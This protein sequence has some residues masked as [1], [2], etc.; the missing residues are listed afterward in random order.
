MKKNSKQLSVATRAIH[1]SKLYAFKGPVTTPIYQTSTYRFETSEDAIRY[2]KGDPSVYVYSRYHN[3]TVHDVEEKIA[4]ME[5]SEAAALFSS[6]MAA[7]TT[8]ILAV[9]K[10]G[11]NIISTSAL[12]GGTYRWMRDE[13][14][15]RNITVHFVDA[16]YLEDI[17]R[18]ADE[19]T[20]IV[21]IE[22]PTNPTLS[23]VD[24]S[25]AVRCTKKAEKRLGRRILTMIDN[26]FATFLNQDPFQFGVDV[27]TESATKYLGG[28]SDI[29]SGV[30][31]GKK[32]YI[33]QVLTL[34]KYHGSCADPF[35]AY[36]LG[37]SLKTFELRVRKQT[38][39][40]LVL[41]RVL[42]KHK[43]VKR[44]LYP[45]LPS[46]PHHKIAKKQMTGFGGMVTIEV[47]PSKRYSPVEAAAKVCDTLTIG[48]NA[49]S[50]GSVETLVSIPVYSS[51]VFMSDE[52]LQRHGVTAGMIRISVGVEGIED[53]I[54]DFEKALAVI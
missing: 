15:N 2:A 14:P 40:A 6:G 8:A 44:V 24:I 7:I 18:I 34:R 36:L 17:A 39:N 45:G 51:H 25:E 10:S 50:L 13:L 21:Y 53:L 5:H 22:T 52:E 20:T 23:I 31:I 1:G 9:T 54:A 11:D 12:Y 4:L 27:I 16:Q 26:T 46:H 41:A 37:R 19:R 49:M 33:E 32:E 35:A 30:V 29:L 38:E 47:K 48:V 43:K 42:E 28:H 3:P